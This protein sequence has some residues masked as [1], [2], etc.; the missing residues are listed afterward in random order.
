MAMARSAMKQDKRF[1]FSCKVKE[2]GLLDLFFFL[3]NKLWKK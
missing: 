2:Q 3:K 1:F